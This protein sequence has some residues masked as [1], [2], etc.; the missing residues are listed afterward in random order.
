MFRYNLLFIIAV[1]W[2]ILWFYYVFYRE[3]NMN[4]QVTDMATDTTEER[5]PNPISTFE[6]AFQN[7]RKI[8]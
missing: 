1:C 7:F 5:I 4:I 3:D 8:I 6:Q 2:F